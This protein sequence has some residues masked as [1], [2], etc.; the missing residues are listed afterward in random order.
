MEAKQ[1][2]TIR[3]VMDQ[4]GPE[5]HAGLLKRPELS[6]EAFDED[7]T[8]LSCFDVALVD[9]RQMRT[10]RLLPWRDRLQLPAVA[11]VDNVE[12]ALRAARWGAADVLIAPVHPSQ[13]AARL[14][15]AVRPPP[16]DRIELGP[17]VLDL[18][19]GQVETPD[20]VRALSESETA[21]AQLLV[22]HPG[23]HFTGVQ[24]QEQALGYA[25][26]TRSRAGD[27]TFYRLRKKVEPDPDAPS[28]FHNTYRKGFRFERQEADGAVRGFLPDEG[29]EL[30]GRHAELEHVLD[31]L[32][33]SSVLLVGTGGVG[34]TQLALGVARDQPPHRWPGGVWWISLRGRRT[35]SDV[36]DAV[37]DAL[38]MDGANVLETALARPRSLF[39][40]DDLD[41]LDDDAADSVRCLVEGHHRLLATSRRTLDVGAEVVDVAPLDLKAAAELFEQRVLQARFGRPSGAAREE[42]QAL[43]RHAGGIPLQVELLASACR[44]RPVSSVTGDLG[45]IAEG[46]DTVYRRS[47]DDLDPS[48]QEALRVVVAFPGGL[49]WTTAEHVV[50]ARAVEELGERSLL[51]LRGRSRIDVLPPVR[52]YVETIRPA[53]ESVTRAFVDGMLHRAQELLDGVAT[54]NHDDAMSAL[55]GEQANLMA[56]VQQA[57][58]LG[59]ATAWRWLVRAL[60]HGLAHRGRPAQRLEWLSSAPEWR[61]AD[62]DVRRLL[63]LS[64]HE[65]LEEAGAL[66]ER[67]L[68]CPLTVDDRVCVLY[69]SS[70]IAERTGAPQAEALS[71]EAVR[72]AEP[73]SWWWGHALMRLANVLRLRGDLAGASSALRRAE[74][75]DLSLEQQADLH[76]LQASVARDAGRMEEAIASARE[77]RAVASALSGR[78][79]SH[80]AFNCG[81]I[82][83]SAGRPREAIDEW[84]V[85][86]DASRA[87][88]DRRTER[89]ALLGLAVTELD[90]G[91]PEEAFRQAMAVV[92]D[93]VLDPTVRG[94]TFV[95]VA[96]CLRHLDRLREA[97]HWLRSALVAA[98]EVGH[99]EITAFVGTHLASLLADLGHVDEAEEILAVHRALFEAHGVAN[100]EDFVEVAAAHI[101]LARDPEGPRTVRRVEAIARHAHEHGADDEVR[102]SGALLRHVLSDRIRPAAAYVQARS[103]QMGTY[104]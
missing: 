16:S 101:E 53:T 14:T 28:F 90:D 63:V 72:T 69:E 57:R 61:T 95:L 8:D 96:L 32:K 88:G 66:A 24:L 51:D 20:G 91:R 80:V 65:Q 81:A 40:L 58:T 60:D 2:T 79:L 76:D 33:R 27:Q 70:R 78:R 34:K 45:L 25:P 12:D 73:G 31:R 1:D 75:A 42:I 86:V 100:A 47:W 17:H 84:H 74:G 55:R 97:H 82:L 103:G 93:P 64:A 102:R 30:C 44:S 38:S 23:V 21:V 9:A 85:A 62:V 6:G 83:H 99:A 11:V 89:R 13:L 56:A 10:D 54:P 98:Q 59:D 19:A 41:Q 22:A 43:V 26:G 94:P 29:V 50:G 67:L 92:S 36:L 77:A 5:L 52:R 37:A 7:A 39:V 68:A 48:L 35:R 18:A 46:S 15:M 87:C 104:P 3:V 71:T 49:P 4:C